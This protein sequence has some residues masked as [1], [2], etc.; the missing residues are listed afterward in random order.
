M[1]AMTQ[2]GNAGE[3]QETSSTTSSSSESSETSTS[4]ESSSTSETSS[5]SSSTSASTTTSTV[6][7]PFTMS[8]PA[9]AFVRTKSP[10][11][12]DLWVTNPTGSVVSALNIKNAS[13]PMKVADKPLITFIKTTEE[14][15]TAVTRLMTYNL[16]TGETKDITIPGYNNKANSVGM[17]GLSPNADIIIYTI[18]PCS[19]FQCDSTA[20][21]TIQKGLYSYQVSSGKHTFLGDI[22]SVSQKVSWDADNRNFYIDDFKNPP[23]KKFLRIDALTGQ[24]TELSNNDSFAQINLYAGAGKWF[25]QTGTSSPSS[26]KIIFNNNGAETT[27]A[28]GSWAE[29]QGVSISTNYNWGTYVRMVDVGTSNKP[30][31]KVIVNLKTFEKKV[32]VNALPTQSALAQDYW[33]NDN[34]L[35]V[36]IQTGAHPNPNITEELYSYDTTTGKLT[37]LTSLGNAGF[38]N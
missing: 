12:G 27:I 37:K 35:I 38:Y 16:S 19:S 11:T 33:V 17:K 36:V 29:Y 20:V 7:P 22:N 28:S 8:G 25:K 6:A 23:I 15:G 31:E 34:L 24:T 3:S 4:T 13:Y 32:I 18:G 5:T 9:V 14:A 2:L 1:I 21:S 10:Y 30:F 26:S